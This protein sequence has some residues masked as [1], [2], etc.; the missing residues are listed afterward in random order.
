MKSEKP[1]CGDVYCSKPYTTCDLSKNHKGNHKC[2]D[3]GILVQEWK[4]KK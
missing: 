3:N 2:I 4:K 1:K